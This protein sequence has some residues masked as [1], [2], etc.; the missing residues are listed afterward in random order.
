[1]QPGLRLCGSTSTI[2]GQI[3][4]SG[5]NHN[6]AVKSLKTILNRSNKLKIYRVKFSSLICDLGRP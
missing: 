3:E 6:A 4:V 2:L 1:M 5:G